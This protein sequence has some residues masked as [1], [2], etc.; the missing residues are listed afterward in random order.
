MIKIEQT[1]W[2]I[3]Q[4]ELTDIRLEVFVREQAVPEEMEIDDEDPSALH[5]IARDMKSG[6]AVATARLLSNGQVGRMAVLKPWRSRGV[7]RQ[8]MKHI[9]DHAHQTGYGTLFLNAQL[10][11]KGFYE[12]AGFEAEGTTFM[13]AG[14]EHVRMKK[15]L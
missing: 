13:D 6:K 10:Y 15:L 4:N 12:K 3:S 11:A 8:L 5:F 1:R 9:I 14:I 7:G 2:V